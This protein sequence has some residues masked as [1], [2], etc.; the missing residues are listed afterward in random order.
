MRSCYIGDL[1][2]QPLAPAPG[3]F[4]PPCLA[5]RPGPVP[6][7]WEQTRPPARP[8]ASSRRSPGKR[9]EPWSRWAAPSA[10]IPAPTTSTRGRGQ[11]EGRRRSPAASIRRAPHRR[12]RANG[13][14]TRRRAAPGAGHG[15]STGGPGRAARRQRGEGCLGRRWPRGEPG[16][17]TLALLSVCEQPAL[18]P[19]VPRWATPGQASS[20]PPPGVHQHPERKQPAAASHGQALE[21]LKVRTQRGSEL[22]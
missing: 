2:K 13:A 10:A 9:W 22:C 15:R 8:V 17:A 1:A 12:S 20:L 4:P 6:K 16:P 3:C 14:G 18:P 7:R 11:G 5:P 21:L 19:L